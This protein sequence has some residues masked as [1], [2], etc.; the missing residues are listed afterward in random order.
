[1]TAEGALLD[2]GNEFGDLAIVP[3]RQSPAADLNLQAFE[4]GYEYFQS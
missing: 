3:D 4:K 1:M 2:L